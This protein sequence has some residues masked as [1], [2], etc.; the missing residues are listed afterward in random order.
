MI[1]KEQIIVAKD[2]LLET[3]QWGIIKG[4][5]LLLKDF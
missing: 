3:E 5:F 4:K 1:E 2:F